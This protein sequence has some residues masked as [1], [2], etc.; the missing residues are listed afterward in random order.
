LGGIPN[1]PIF[2]FCLDNCDE[3]FQS[4]AGLIAIILNFAN[5]NGIKENLMQLTTCCPFCF[6]CE[7]SIKRGMKTFG[8]SSFHSL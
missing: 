8:S 1:D 6:E 7:S 4:N 2:I 3:A 5:E